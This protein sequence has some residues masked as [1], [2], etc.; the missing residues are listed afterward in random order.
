MWQ[1]YL[2]EV[3]TEVRL[4]LGIFSEDDHLRCLLQE[5]FEHGDVSNGDVLW[6]EG[7]LGLTDADE[8]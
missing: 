8:V 7:P 4:G 6:P 3:R 1:A 2:D 5:C